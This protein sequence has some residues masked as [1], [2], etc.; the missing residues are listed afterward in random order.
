MP[1][2][3][4]H[5]LE[6]KRLRQ[7]LA[8]ASVACLTGAGISAESGIPTFRGTDGLWKKFRPEELASIDAFLSHPELVLEWYKFRRE[9]MATALPNAGHQALAA[10]QAKVSDFCLITQNVDGLHQKAG[11]Q[12]VVELHGNIWFDRCMECGARREAGMAEDVLQ[13][14]CGGRLRPDVVWFGEWLPEAALERAF[15]KAGGCELF[16]SIGTSAVVQP[17][18]DLPLLAKRSGACLIEIN[19]EPTP[20]SPLADYTFFGKAG[21]LLPELLEAVP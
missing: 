16:L 17:A 6:D 18:A 21:E 5:R 14:T 3:S 12:Q 2:L 20:L 19:P 11:S 1:R 7:A 4:A 10:W 13:C 15:E 9:R 8:S